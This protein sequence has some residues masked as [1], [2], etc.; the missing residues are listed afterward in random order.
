MKQTEEIVGSRARDTNTS[1]TTVSLS[2][3]TVNLNTSKGKVLGEK[4]KRYTFTVTQTTYLEVQ[5]ERYTL[6]IK[7]SRLN[8]VVVFTRESGE[9][10]DVE[11]INTWV[12]SV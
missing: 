3:K 8:V 7:E 5:F 2:L 9:N 4:R 1:T 10:F 11:K 6:N 12:R